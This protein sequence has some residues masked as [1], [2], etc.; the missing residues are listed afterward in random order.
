M[1]EPST[2]PS[3][4]VADFMQ[5]PLMP[6]AEQLRCLGY[7]LLNC[8]LSGEEPDL[9]TWFAGRRELP[10]LGTRRKAAQRGLFDGLWL[11]QSAA[12]RVLLT[13]QRLLGRPVHFDYGATVDGVVNGKLTETA[14]RS[15][16]MWELRRRIGLDDDRQIG[17]D[18][19]PLVTELAWGDLQ[20][21]RDA[22]EMVE[23]A[24]RQRTL[25]RPGEFVVTPVSPRTFWLLILL[26]IG[27]TAPSWKDRVRR[28]RHRTRRHLD[29]L[30]IVATGEALHADWAT[31]WDQWILSEA[32]VQW[33]CARC[34]Q[35]VQAA[36]RALPLNRL[37]GM[38]YQ[39]EADEIR[40]VA[41]RLPD[42]EAAMPSWMVAW[43]RPKKIRYNE[44]DKDQPVIVQKRS[45]LARLRTRLRRRPRPAGMDANTR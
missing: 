41:L 14:W 43:F 18:F 25:F 34:S 19:W 9:H 2:L 22:A 30:Q 5:M 4:P 44:S 24:L 11:W 12:G 21:Q 27:H 38:S 16:V 1:T 17:A 40:P 29:Y 10:L 20:W 35:G 45:L 37:R 13:V 26:A 3:E 39:P 33:G 31:V 42:W 6:A 28:S 8:I 23:Q 32:L 36:L 15:R 7:Y